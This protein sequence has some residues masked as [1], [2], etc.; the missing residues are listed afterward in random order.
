MLVVAAEVDKDQQDQ[1]ELVVADTQAVSTI[2]P[3]VNLLV[4]V[5]AVAHMPLVFI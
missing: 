2:K 5:V 3:V 1:V 4:L